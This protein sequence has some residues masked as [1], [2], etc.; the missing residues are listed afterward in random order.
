MS[1]ANNKIECVACSAEFT[2]K[3]DDEDFAAQYCPNCG[4]EIMGDIEIVENIDP[5][6]LYDEF[7]D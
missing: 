3:F 6:F 5:E 2:V 1:S 7:D 4:N